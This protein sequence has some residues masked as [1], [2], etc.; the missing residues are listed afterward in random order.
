MK[1]YC[2]CGNWIATLEKGSKIKKG[3]ELSGLCNK[4]LNKYDSYQYD[5]NQVVDNLKNMFRMT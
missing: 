2:K 5:E 3:A 4:C 1:I